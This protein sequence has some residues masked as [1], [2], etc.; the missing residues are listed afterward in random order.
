MLAPTVLIVTLAAALML[1]AG[2]ILGSFSVDINTNALALISDT[3]GRSSTV[4]KL[5]FFYITGEG[6]Q[7]P[8]IT[9][10]S[11]SNAKLAHVQASLPEYMAV[12]ASTC[13]DWSGAGKLMSALDRVHQAIEVGEHLISRENIFPY[14]RDIVTLA[15]DITNGLGWLVL[16]ESIAGVLVLPCFVLAA[17][18]YL[19]LKSDWYFSEG[20]TSK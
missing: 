4:H 13:P 8:L 2:T 11:D 9:E 19:A 3:A 12:L 14:Y 17:H 15:V 5:S 1:Y 7:P 16:F 18:R 6:E 20:S 10:L